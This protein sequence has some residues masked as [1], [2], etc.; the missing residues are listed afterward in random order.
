MF[1]VLYRNNINIMAISTSEIKIS[2][3][4]EEK[5]GELAVRE[6][7]SAFIEE[8]EEVQVINS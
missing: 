3:L 4:I 2:C 6:L 5:Y 8:G 7:H 1:E